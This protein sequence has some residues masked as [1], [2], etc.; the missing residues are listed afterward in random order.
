MEGSVKARGDW[1]GPT[2][3]ECVFVQFE[4]R[5]VHAL[6]LQAGLGGL[7]VTLRSVRW[8]SCDGRQSSPHSPSMK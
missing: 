2:H 8:L 3:H 7:A 6:P 1:Y 4:E 5:V